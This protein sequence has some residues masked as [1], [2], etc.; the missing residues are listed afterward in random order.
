MCSGAFQSEFPEC[1]LWY[2]YDQAWFLIIKIH[3]DNEWLTVVES[4]II[5]CAEIILNLT[6]TYVLNFLN[7]QKKLLQSF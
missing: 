6:T 3:R 1:T 5:W 2:M 4:V 7:I